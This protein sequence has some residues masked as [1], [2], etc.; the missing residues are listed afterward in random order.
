MRTV[1]PVSSST[2]R[3][4][5]SSISSP[6]SGVPLG[7]AEGTRRLEQ[8][9]VVDDEREVAVEELGG[10]PRQHHAWEEDLEVLHDRRHLGVDGE[11]ER[12]ELL[13]AADLDLGRGD[14]VVHAVVDVERG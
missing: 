10:A 6:W 12:D 9:G 1:R 4:A 7:K 2:S 5:V 3:R 14:R 8:T 13:L 11:L